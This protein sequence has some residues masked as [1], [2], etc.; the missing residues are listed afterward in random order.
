MN[1]YTKRIQKTLLHKPK[2]AIVIGS[3]MN[4]LPSII[5][6]FDTVF[7]HS[8]TGMYVKDKKVATVNDY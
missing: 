5:E 6:I 1:K 2:D 7:L 8:R 4:L 3:G